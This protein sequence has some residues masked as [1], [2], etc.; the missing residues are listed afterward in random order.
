MDVRFR[1]VGRRLEPRP[2]DRDG[3]HQQGRREVRGEGV[4]QSQRGGELCA[5]Q[6]GSEDP[7]RYVEPHPGHRA[8]PLVGGRGEVLLQLD[9]V[10]GERVDVPVQVAAQGAAGP[11]IG[12]RSAAESQVDAPGKERGERAELL[13]DHQRRMVRQHDPAR[14]DADRR[15]GGGHVPDDHRGGGARDARHVVM[16]GQPEPPVAPAL[17][18]PR[19]VRGVAQR[20]G[21][22]AAFRDGGEI[23]ERE[24]RHDADLLYV[25]TSRCEVDLQWRLPTAT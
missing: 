7:D 12:A 9:H 15:R 24:R 22:V 23:E 5:E 1:A 13:R 4:G 19:Q 14:A 18:V 20:H 3:L 8:H 6:A 2:I 25:W 11:L 10:A 16:L 21:G 17:R